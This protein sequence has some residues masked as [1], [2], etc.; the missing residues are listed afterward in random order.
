MK[1]KLSQQQKRRITQRQ[2]KSLQRAGHESGA[3]DAASEDAPERPGTV[4]AHFGQELLIRDDAT[5][6]YAEHRALARRNVGDLVAGDE[7]SWI[8]GPDERVVITAR[9]ERRTDLRR[10]D[11]F[12]RLRTVAA[13]IDQVIVVIAPEPEPHDNL[14]DRYLAVAEINELTA[15]L[16]LNKTDLLNG[17]R[18]RQM[19]NLLV[20]YEKL[21]YQ[22]LRTSASVASEDPE[23]LNRLAGRTSVFAGQS[24]VGKS[25]IIQNLLPQHDLRVGALSENLKGTHTTT[26]ARLYPL[27]SGGALI[28]SPGIREFGLWNL[29]EEELTEGFIDIRRFA[30]DCRFRDCRHENEP[31]CGLDQAVKRGDL[32]PERLASYRRIRNELSGSDAARFR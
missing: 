19:A 28:D 5:T 30:A 11:R 23:L 32:A 13:N 31:G 21:G 1:R 6:E 29:T 14:I 27:S 9:K 8:P 2:K 4:L 25:S 26:T 12:G 22:V 7:I 3:T 10:P 24:G 17:D 18:R 20:R 15:V 16:L